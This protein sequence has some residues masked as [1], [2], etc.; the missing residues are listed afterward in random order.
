MSR[1]P[2]ASSALVIAT[3]N[4]ADH[5]L[6]TVEGIVRQSVLPGELCIVD[7]S[8]D[9]P[10]TREAIEGLCSAAGLPLIYEHPSGRGSCH[11]RNRGVKLTSGDPVIFTDDD[12]WLSPDCHTELVAEYDRWGPELGGLCGAD[13]VA[14]EMAVLSV[15]WRRLFGMST[16]TPEATGRMKAGFYVDGISQS[17]GVKRV[18]YMNGWLMSYRRH[19]LEQFE[20]DEA[21]PGYAQK[22]DMDLAFRVSRKYILARTPAATGKHYKAGAQRLSK[23]QLL[24]VI[25]ANQ[26]YLHR[27]NMPQTLPYRAALWWAQV[28]VLTL[29]TTKAIKNRDPGFVTGMIVGAWEQVRR[30]GLVDPALEDTRRKAAL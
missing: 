10:G 9:P 23:H 24:R 16:W 18:E 26:F 12:V 13:L 30:R 7:S 5:L 1:P 27:K 21:M 20:F 11:Q 2:R 4:R 14:R 25:M 3:R 19:V 15:L 29:N 6:E 17:A 28:G 22:E 8:D